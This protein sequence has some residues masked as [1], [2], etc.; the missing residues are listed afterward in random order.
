MNFIP[1]SY[2]ETAIEL[3][4]TQPNFALFMDPGCGKTI[5][6]LTALKAFRPKR[7]LL[8][9]PLEIIYRVWPREIKKWD[10]V[11]DLTYTILHGPDKVAN[12]RLA[13]DIYLINPEGLKW[14]N[15]HV[16][17]TRCWPYSVLVID[18][19]TVFKN[20]QSKQFTEHL[21]PIL[22][23]FS[24]RYILSGTPI[25]KSYLE[26]W[27]Q[28]Y[29]LDL[30]KRLTDNYHH[31][32]NKYFYRSDF[33]GYK[34]DLFPDYDVK[35]KELVKDITIHVSAE[36][37]LDL[38]E[39]V[40]N[41]ILIDLDSK[42]RKMYSSMVK[43]LLIS[44]DDGSVISAANAAVK[45]GK[46]QNISNGFLYISEVDLYTGR[47]VITGAHNI[48]EKKLDALESIISELNGN[49]ILVGF[50]YRQDLKLLLSRFPNTPYFGSGVPA[51]EKQRIEDEW[52]AGNI[53]ILFAQI[54]STAKGLNLQHSGHH[55]AFYSMIWN[56]EDA[57]QFVKRIARQGQKAHHVFV[58]R[59]MGKNTIDE[60]IAETLD[61]RKDQSNNFLWSLKSHLQ[62]TSTM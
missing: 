25:P 19:S 12:F 22:S 40:Y 37:Y 60:F 58:H 8:I 50:H 30:G 45:T 55:I 52:N 3:V 39:I 53:P 2:Q 5:V 26:L 31:Y 7:T 57:D 23:N 29:I 13:K 4:L 46:L 35:I 49:P 15:Q 11:N 54:H 9:A 44:F 47:K 41:D 18:E 56:F 33:K 21:Q 42:T 32:R 27:A 62:M 17:T 43:D 36:D 14:L 61:Q 59:L 48:H 10:Q 38:P 24:R 6:T 51:D 28:Y 16:R 20:F 1:H 34:W